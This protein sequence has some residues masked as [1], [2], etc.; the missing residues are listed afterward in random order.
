M[1]RARRTMKSFDD[2]TLNER[3]RVRRPLVAARYR[4]VRKRWHVV[5]A[6]VDAV[7]GLLVRAAQKLG[8][9]G[10]KSSREPMP[11]SAV[12]RILLVHLD[13][14]GDAIITTAMLAPLRARY[15]HAR[16]EVLS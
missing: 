6:I 10:K 4:Y 3:Q 9:A 5:M 15:A 2:A 14:L 16:I 1:P 8:L 7:M 13:H 12:R 11:P